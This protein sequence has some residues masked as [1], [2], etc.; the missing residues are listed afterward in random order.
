MTINQVFLAIEI[1]KS[2]REPVSQ[3]IEI[4]V[5]TSKPQSGFTNFSEENISGR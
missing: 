4:N 1:S 3:T 2:N 5:S